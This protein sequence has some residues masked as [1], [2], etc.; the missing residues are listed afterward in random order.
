M[1]WCKVICPISTAVS[2]P[3]CI[4]KE[5]E[6]RTLPSISHYYTLHGLGSWPNEGMVRTV[7]ENKNTLCHGSTVKAEFWKAV[8]FTDDDCT[9]V[10]FKEVLCSPPP[11][12]YFL[13]SSLPSL[14]PAQFLH[15][16][17]EL[18]FNMNIIILSPWPV[19][20]NGQFYIQTY[21]VLLKMWHI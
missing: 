2:W 20:R 16:K 4:R 21:N 17:K 3:K 10:A 13:F 18:N 8:L 19:C 11:S 14:L 9:S 15:T 12:S 6:E 5:K 7:W 1:W